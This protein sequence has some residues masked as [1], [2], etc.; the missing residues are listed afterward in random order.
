MAAWLAAIPVLGSFFKDVGEAID[1]NVTTDEERLK[2]KADMMGLQVPVVMAVVEAQ[3]SANELQAKLV[4][5][6]LKSEHW[7]VWSRRPILSYAAFL[8]AIGASVF[9]YMDS[10]NAWWLAL[11]ING[12]DV[13]TRGAAGLRPRRDLSVG[14]ARLFRKQ[15]RSAKGG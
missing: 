14:P 11:A 1:R 12:L 9:G 8:N 7:L 4:E 13:G 6:E 3:K 5:A 15:H 10:E 2:M